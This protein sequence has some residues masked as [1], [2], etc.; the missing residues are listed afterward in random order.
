MRFREQFEHHKMPEWY[1]HYFDYDRLK[2][3]INYFKKKNHRNPLLTHYLVSKHD[4]HHGHHDHSGDTSH[5][6]V[7]N[8]LLRGFYTL[9]NKDN[10]VV[11]VNLEQT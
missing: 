4:D 8:A 6:D 2:D 11:P 10:S 3:G 7:S 9:S 1:S 5:G